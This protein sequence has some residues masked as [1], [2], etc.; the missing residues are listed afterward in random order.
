[1][2]DLYVQRLIDIA[3]GDE[4][5]WPPGGNRFLHEL[6]YLDDATFVFDRL[7]GKRASDKK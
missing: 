6:I 1:M 2:Y 3:F 7:I 4:P 5:L